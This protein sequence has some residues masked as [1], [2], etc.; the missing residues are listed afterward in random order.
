MEMS[1]LNSKRNK[2]KVFSLF[3]LILIFVQFVVW[4]QCPNEGIISFLKYY[5]CAI[6]VVGFIVPLLFGTNIVHPY[7]LYLFAF[8]VFMMSRVFLD[9]FGVESAFF[10]VATWANDWSFFSQPIRFEML[11]A[12]AFFLLFTSLG[13]LSVFYLTGRLR[14]NGNIKK[15]TSIIIGM[16]NFGFG[17]FIV[18][19]IPYLIYLYQAVKYVIDNG[20]LLVYLNESESTIT[21]PILRI[22]DDFCMAGLFLYLS[23]FPSG[24]KYKFVLSFY[25]F[26]L[27]AMLG[28]GGRTATFTQIFAFVAYLGFRGLQIDK[29]RVIYL[30]LTGF[31]LIYTAQVV[32]DFRENGFQSLDSKEKS[33]IPIMQL[34]QT[35]FWQQGTS[36][37][38]IGRTIEHADDVVNG[39][40]YFCGP[41]TNDLRKNP[42]MERLDLGIPQ[43]QVAET[44]KKGYSWADKLSYMVAPKYYLSGHGMGSSTVAESYILGGMFGVMIV[45]FLFTFCVILFVERYKKSYTGI[46]LL[47][48][49]LPAFFISPRAAPLSIVSALFRPLFILFFIQLFFYLKQHY[50]IYSMD[51]KHVG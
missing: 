35:F 47:F 29:K 6:Y 25:I 2:I 24:K 49:I 30:G 51:S 21:N 31:G 19:A 5:V 23:T 39:W 43:G 46:F 44:V 4:A 10:D 38:T 41:V 37:Q 20:Y 42:I 12:L 27:L 34:V 7:I 22:S 32:N 36:I 45:G 40:L 28:T 17:L 18:F 50:L 8:G 26:T 14:S 11:N 3:Y 9:A 48:F 1:V 33:S 15:E 13:A 16:R